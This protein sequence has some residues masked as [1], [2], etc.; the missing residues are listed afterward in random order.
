MLLDKIEPRFD[1]PITK[2][3]P[4]S[5]IGNPCTIKKVFYIERRKVNKVKFSK[6]QPDN[7]A[8]RMSYWNF[9]EKTS[10]LFREYSCYVQKSGIYNRKI[11]ERLNRDYKILKKIFSNSI[12]YGITLPDDLKINNKNVEDIFRIDSEN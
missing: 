3:F 10:S 7:L 12:I 2:I 6:I 1:L 11:D 4:G 5:K 9:Y 8:R